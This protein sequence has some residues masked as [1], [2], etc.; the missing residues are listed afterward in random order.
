MLIHVQLE[1]FLHV[2]R[3]GDNYAQ[4]FVSDTVVLRVKTLLY[5][6]NYLIKDRS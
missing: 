1:T 2:I 3:T 4:C 5:L 6:R